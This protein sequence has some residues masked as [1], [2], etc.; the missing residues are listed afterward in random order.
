VETD[1]AV[2]QPR[3]AE[4]G[5]VRAVVVGRAEQDAVVEVGRAG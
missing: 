1:V 4:R 5:V 3:E 2:R